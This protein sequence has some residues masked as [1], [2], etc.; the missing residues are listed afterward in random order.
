MCCLC[1]GWY[2]LSQPKLL[3]WV[4]GSWGTTLW[5]KYFATLSHL[6]PTTAFWS[7][8]E[9][10]PLRSVWFSQL[11]VYSTRGGSG[12]WCGGVHKGSKYSSAEF[13]FKSSSV[14]SYMQPAALKSGRACQKCRCLSHTLHLLN[15]NPHFN[16]NLMDLC[17]CSSLRSVA[18]AHRTFN[19]D[20]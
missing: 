20:K 7:R 1:L 13:F 17:A 15:Q 14:N 12:D 5:A 19:S 11:A 18:L 9:L 16:K 8:P 10:W 4:K 6:I 2:M 3:I